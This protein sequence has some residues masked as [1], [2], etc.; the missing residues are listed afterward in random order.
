MSL[1]MLV[2][3]LVDAGG[4]VEHR[5]R[6][7]RVVDGAPGAG[8]RRA[9]AHA[10]RPLPAALT[11]VGLAL[12]VARPRRG[13]VEAGLVAARARDD[14]QVV[15][16][17]AGRGRD[18]VAGRA[19]RDA[20]GA[21]RRRA[22]R[23]RRRWRSGRRSRRSAA[24][25]ARWSAS[26]STG[27]CRSSRRRRPCSR[28]VGG[29]HVTGDPIRHDRFKSN[30]LDGGA[31]DAVQAAEHRSRCWSPALAILWLAWRRP[32]ADALVLASLAVTLAFV[33][34]SKVLSPQYVVWLLPLAAAAWPRRAPGRRRSSRVA[35]A[36]HPAV[37][38]GPLLR[39][40]PPARRGPWWP[41][42][43]ER[44]AAGG[45]GRHGTSTCS[46]ASARRGAPSTG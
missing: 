9:G 23:R 11:L 17:G 14:D 42:A 31:A 25:R 2:C 4:G 8:R 5:R 36:G 3:A 30:G 43:Q 32:T 27:R 18:P 19:R 37:V 39:R 46:I 15:A 21:A 45:A 29:S 16:G 10:L 41:S 7:R 33:A 28:C 20:P 22:L 6:A 12:I 13:A 26:T 34:L 1:L 38:P 24:S 44:P 40:R 35:V